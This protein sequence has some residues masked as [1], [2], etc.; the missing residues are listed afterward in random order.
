MDKPSA[1]LPNSVERKIGKSVKI[2]YTSGGG[3]DFDSEEAANIIQA[4]FNSGMLTD[5]TILSLP[6]YGRILIV[7]MRDVSSIEVGN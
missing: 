2:R 1:R 6:Y 3:C 5:R 4:A 7:N